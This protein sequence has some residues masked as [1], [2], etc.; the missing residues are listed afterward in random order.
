MHHYSLP[1]NTEFWWMPLSVESAI[2][3]HQ[4]GAYFLK[5]EL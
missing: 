2:D 1:S 3:Q 5:W 4:A